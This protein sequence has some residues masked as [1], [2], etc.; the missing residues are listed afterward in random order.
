M[1][2]CIVGIGLLGG[3][4]ALGIKDKIS[5]LKITGVDANPEHAK[6]ALELG[7]VQEI[8]N[9]EAAVAE[10]D[11][12]VLAIPVNAIISLLPRVLDV[13]ASTAIVI[14]LGSTKELIC[15]A[16]QDH[17]RRHQFVAVHPIAGTENTG[18]EAAFASLL[19]GK[20]MIICEK[21]KSDPVA[22]QLIEELCRN[23]EMRISY[24]DAASHDLHLAYVSHLSHISSFALGITVLDKEKNEQNI[25][26]MA[27]S[28]FSSTVRLAKSSP[29]MWAP[30]FTQ[31]GKNIS[32]A[33][34]SYI[35]KL[36]FF[37][38]I[39]DNQDESSSYALMKEA[40]EIR[41]ILQGIK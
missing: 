10:A 35:E 33:L 31:N 3:S 32:E 8:L 14:D 34:A 13:M 22:V 29:D 27:G 1:K 23:L 24:M 26:D 11:L 21:E 2:L 18:P 41:R 12:I 37:K 9:L 19:P 28:G 6:K 16:V 7:I 40:N 36:Q 20:T 5:D 4:F 39:I 38:K 17:P 15:A 25:F 30:I